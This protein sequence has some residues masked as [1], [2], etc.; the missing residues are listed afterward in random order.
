MTTTTKPNILFWRV[1]KRTVPHLFTFLAAVQCAR[2]ND[3]L[4]F[5][6]IAALAIHYSR[7]E[8]K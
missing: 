6:W 5:V 4:A 1:L 2:G 8:L 7:E 3:W